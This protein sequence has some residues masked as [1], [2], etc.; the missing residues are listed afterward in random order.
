MARTMTGFNSY[1]GEILRN[2]STGDATEHTHRPAL[3]AML[4]SLESNITATNEPKRIEAGAPDYIL[5]RVATP[6]GYVEAK[7]I[8]ENLQ[9]AERSQ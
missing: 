2:L 9:R 7:D 8:G 5:T 4:E 6:V 3:K 1:L